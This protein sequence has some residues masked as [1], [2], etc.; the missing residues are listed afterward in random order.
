[1]SEERTNNPTEECEEAGTGTPPPS[2]VE[3]VVNKKTG[4]IVFKTP[5]GQTLTAKAT[6][7]E[8]DNDDQTNIV[9]QPPL[10]PEQFREAL[11]RFSDLGLVWTADRPPHVKPGDKADDSVLLSPEFEQF[12]SDYPRLPREVSSIAFH[13]ITGSECTADIAGD[14]ETLRKKI[15]IAREFYLNNEF[16]DEFFFKHAIKVPYFNQ[17]D[18][19]VVIKAAEKNVHIFA[20]VAYALLS[21][22][23]DSPD[24]SQAKKQTLTVA[25]NTALVDK[26]IA[27]LGE[28]KKALGVSTDLAGKLHGIIEKMTA[29]ST[30]ADTNNDAKMAS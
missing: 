4:D 18:W 9:D 3:L 24:G 28:V 13:Y 16:R 23:L 15:E 20:G 22:H 14:T 25:V 19:E 29:E 8:D 26:L 30:N 12:Q 5:N 1:M 6:I 2:A 11:Q 21:L 7:I 27:T 17:I 10:T